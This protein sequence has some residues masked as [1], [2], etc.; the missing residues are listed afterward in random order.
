MGTKFILCTDI[1]NTYY[2][3]KEL[4]PKYAC[5]LDFFAHFDLKF[6]HKLGMLNAVPGALSR[7]VVKGFVATPTAMRLIFYLESRKN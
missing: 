7:K 4:N 3:Q 6:E 5:W 1:S 2:S